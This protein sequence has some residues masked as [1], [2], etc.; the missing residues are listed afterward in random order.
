MRNFQTD[1][2]IPLISNDMCDNCQ[3]ATGYWNAWQEIRDITYRQLKEAA[4][5]YPTYRV[6]ATGH[7]MGGTV[8]SFAATE[9][10][11][12]GRVVD[13]VSSAAFILQ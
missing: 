4:D 2:N 3:T 13:I 6:V 10:R 11:D 12:S 9:L 8:A 1:I 7:S 5:R